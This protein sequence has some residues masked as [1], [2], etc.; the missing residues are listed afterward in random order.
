MSTSRFDIEHVTIINCPVDKVWE[1]LIA[2]DD[3][4]WNLWTRLEA[5]EAKTGV[6]GKLKACYEGDNVE[7]KTF[8][9]VFGHVSPEQHILTWQG[10]VGPGGCLFQG[11][12]TMQ[13][14]A[15][16]ENTTRLEHSE[17]FNGLLPQLGLGLPYERL[18]ENYLKMNE[19]LKAHVE[20]L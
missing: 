4:E 20:Q 15:I 9:F 19:A 18:N 3:W 12:H 2:I 13:L 1:S 11:V 8:D 17:K 7:W 16:D 6:A 5:A 10:S 14:K